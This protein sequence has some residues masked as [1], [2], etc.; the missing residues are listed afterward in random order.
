ME[1]EEYFLFFG[2]EIFEKLTFDV[3]VQSWLL[4]K[5]SKRRLT[6]HPSRVFNVVR[7]WMGNMLRDVFKQERKSH[8]GKSFSLF[9]LTWC[10]CGVVGG[11][12][13]NALIVLRFTRMLQVWNIRPAFTIKINQL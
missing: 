1:L 12:W 11:G 13:L 4:T 10:R 8:H 2:G 6:H 7:Q 9:F 3:D 5:C